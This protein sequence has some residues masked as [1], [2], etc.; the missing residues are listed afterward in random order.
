MTKKVSRII[1]SSRSRARAPGG[2]GAEGE[3]PKCPESVRKVSKTRGQWGNSGHCYGGCPKVSESVQNGLHS[4]RSQTRARGVHAPQGKCPKVS[5][6]VRG[7]V[8]AG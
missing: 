7:A 1:Q 4:E 8:V 6:G 3:C 2:Y 5:T